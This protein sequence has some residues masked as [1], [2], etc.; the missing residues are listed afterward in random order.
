MIVQLLFYHKRG[1]SLAI[2]SEFK[3]NAIW[4]AA[5]TRCGT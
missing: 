2:G 4:K 3:A 5:D 1:G